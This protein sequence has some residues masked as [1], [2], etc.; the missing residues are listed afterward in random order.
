MHFAV[1]GII[2]TIFVD[3]VARA[4]ENSFI[5]RS[6]MSEIESEHAQLS[7]ADTLNAFGK[8]RTY[9]FAVAR[10]YA[11]YPIH[12]FVALP[13]EIIVIIVPATVAAEDLVA[14]PR[15]YF[16]TSLTVSFC[17][18][19]DLLFKLIYSLFLMTK[20]LENIYK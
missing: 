20:I 3:V 2:I 18:H 6:K 11:V 13:A 7:G 4:S 12:P 14:P 5:H 16:A 15:E 9:D 8:Q 19:K 17:T 10:K 1:G